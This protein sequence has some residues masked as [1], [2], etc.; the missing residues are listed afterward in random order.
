M[1]NYNNVKSLIDK[2]DK[3]DYSYHSDVFNILRKYQL[4]Y[5]KN[6]NGFFFDFQ[7]LEDN[8]IDELTTYITNIEN[9]VKISQEDTNTIL[10][11]NA[12]ISPS[13]KDNTVTKHSLS[14]E[15]IDVLKTLNDKMDNKLDVNPLLYII[16][17]DKQVTRRTT[18]NKFTIAKKKYSK[19][20]IVEIKYTMLDLLSNDIT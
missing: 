7:N 4:K 14:E 17:K 15:C 8:I 9:C 18:S 13:P 5:S 3:M 12:S 16:D 10:P 2:I 6:N 20:I 1:S 19:P 11:E